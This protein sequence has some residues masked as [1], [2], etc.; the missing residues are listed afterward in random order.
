LAPLARRARDGRALAYECA[1]EIASAPATSW[2]SS[3]GRG[4]K[5]WDRNGQRAS[6]ARAAGSRISQ[7]DRRAETE[8]R[9]GGQVSCGVRRCASPPCGWG[10]IMRISRTLGIAH[11]TVWKYAHAAEFP[12]RAPHRRQHSILDPYLAHLLARHAA[13]CENSEQL[14]REIRHLGYSGTQKQVRRWLHERRRHPAPTTPHQYRRD[15]LRIAEGGTHDGERDASAVHHTVH[16]A[17]AQKSMAPLLPSPAQ[18]SWLLIQ[19]LESLSEAAEPVN[20]FETPRWTEFTELRPVRSL[21]S[22]GAWVG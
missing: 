16:Q 13:G 4:A 15:W 7:D 22:R 12:D 19:P 8:C 1:S 6:G 20:G 17:A 9:L 11:G 21:T 14:W 2:R 10:P 5:L 3:G 18:L